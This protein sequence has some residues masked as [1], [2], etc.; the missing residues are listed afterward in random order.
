M[1]T[2][3]RKVIPLFVFALL[4]ALAIGVSAKH[5]IASGTEEP[6]PADDSASKGE[7]V[8][9]DEDAAGST[10]EQ[11]APSGSGTEKQTDKSDPHDSH[12]HGGSTTERK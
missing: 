9:D 1:K 6:P 8:S 4:A 7:D 10:T 3:S 5:A 11:P 2:Y 12:S